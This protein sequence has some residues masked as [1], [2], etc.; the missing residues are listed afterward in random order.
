LNIILHQF[1]IV[2]TNFGGLNSGDETKKASR[3]SPNKNGGLT[4]NIEK[5]GTT[6]PGNHTKS[7]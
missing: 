7:Y 6:R 4:K 2:T 5:H 3:E 1:F